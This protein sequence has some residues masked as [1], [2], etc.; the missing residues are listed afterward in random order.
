MRS[1]QHI[2]LIFSPCVFQG[3]RNDLTIVRYFHDEEIKRFQTTNN[4]LA[5]DLA[6]LKYAVSISVVFRELDAIIFCEFYILGEKH[7]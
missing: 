7:K 3:F 6:N 5:D 2:T 4:Q 1:N